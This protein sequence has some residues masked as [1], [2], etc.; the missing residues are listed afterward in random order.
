MQ[1]TTLWAVKSRTSR[2]LFIQLTKVT[3]ISSARLVLQRLLWTSSFLDALLIQHILLKFI[4]ASP[5]FGSTII[6]RLRHKRPLIIH[7]LVITLPLLLHL[8]FCSPLTL[9]LLGMEK[10]ST[11]GSKLLTPTR[12]RQLVQS[13][14]SSRSL[15]FMP[16]LAMSLQLLLLLLTSVLRLIRMEQ[17]LRPYQLQQ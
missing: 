1:T 13:M 8:I 9:E 16:V 11:L 6:L 3:A 12:V 5:K 7:I 17:P 14:M 4:T 10:Q 2:R 15:L